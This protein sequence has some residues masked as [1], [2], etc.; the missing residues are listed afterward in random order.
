MGPTLD[1]PS[2]ANSFQ[3]EYVRLAFASL[4]RWSGRNLIKDLKLPLECLGE[5]VYYGDFYLL[6]HNGAPDPVL[7]YGNRR[8]LEQWECTWSQLT[9]MYARDTA[10]S[11]EQSARQLVMSE[12]LQKGFLA[13]YN[14]ER[15]SRTGKL[16]RIQDVIIWNIVGAQNQL[17]GQAA[18]FFSVA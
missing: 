7:N 4:E 9:S 13:G 3:E 18:F 16:F 5:S 2:A 11:D 15:I 8:A 17:I 12:V 6:T 14:G 1:Q 10:K